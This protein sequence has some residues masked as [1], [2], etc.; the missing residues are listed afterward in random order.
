MKVG[1]GM[2]RSRGKGCKDQ[3]N[4]ADELRLCVDYQNEIG[5]R[6][7]IFKAPAEEGR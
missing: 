5:L 7:D 2:G 6:H 1:G 3:Q 4:A